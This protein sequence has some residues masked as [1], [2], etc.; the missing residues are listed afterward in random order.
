[1][2]PE[3]VER[4]LLLKKRGLRQQVENHAIGQ[5]ANASEVREAL[6]PVEGNDSGLGIES[7][8]RI[9]CSEKD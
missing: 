9:V 8:E 6:I 3:A 5:S 2:G 7:M 1:M 4:T